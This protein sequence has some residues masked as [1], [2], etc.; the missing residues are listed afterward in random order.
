M[1]P[2]TGRR[3]WMPV[4][5]NSAPGRVVPPSRPGAVI[6]VLAAILA[7]LIPEG[8]EAVPELRGGFAYSDHDPGAM[9]PGRRADSSQCP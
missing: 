9:T 5:G 8:L 2:V 7:W 1:S 6:R 4:D 3:G